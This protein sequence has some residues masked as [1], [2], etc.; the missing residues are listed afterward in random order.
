M[1]SSVLE[2]LTK[3]SIDLYLDSIDILKQVAAETREKMAQYATNDCVANAR[4]RWDRQVNSHG[5]RINYCLSEATRILNGEYYDLNFFDKD[6]SRVSNHTP[7]QSLN[8]LSRNDIFETRGDF[9][10]LINRRLRDL[11]LRAGREFA[12]LT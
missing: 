7:N 3:F 4:E 5:Y 12:N 9:Y 8:I 10:T 2:G 11:V 1:I 6:G